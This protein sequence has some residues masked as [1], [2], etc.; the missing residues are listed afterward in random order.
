MCSLSLSLSLS[1]GVHSILVALMA[2]KAEVRYDPSMVLPEQVAASISELGFPSS[3]M[4][5]AGA[6][7]GEVDL[8]VGM[9]TRLIF[10]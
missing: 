8:E 4:E 10:L 3:V 7:Q 9:Y 2:A 6:G 1:P 5:E